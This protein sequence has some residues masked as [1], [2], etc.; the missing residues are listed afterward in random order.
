[1]YAIHAWKLPLDPRFK[2]IRD[3]FNRLVSY[4][5]HTQW[6]ATFSTDLHY[7]FYVIRFVWR[8]VRYES[9]IFIDQVWLMYM[10]MVRQSRE[11]FAKIHAGLTFD[12]TFRPLP[13]RGGGGEK[14][15]T[16]IR[17]KNFLQSIIKFISLK[18]IFI[19]KIGVHVT[20]TLLKHVSNAVSRT[21]HLPVIFSSSSM[22]FQLLP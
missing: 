6:R 12:K 10:M 2:S 13:T 21:C 17:L 9:F 22:I 19:H 14:E 5:G 1:M 11:S 8:S 4:I 7:L 15:E 16:T 3:I 20:I 18:F